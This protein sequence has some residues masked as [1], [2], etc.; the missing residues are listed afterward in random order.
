MPV[1]VFTVR[2]GSERW[3]KDL[4]EESH[5][6]DIFQVGQNREIYISRRGIQCSHK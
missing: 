1:E 2:S 3:N 6:S 5:P 4:D